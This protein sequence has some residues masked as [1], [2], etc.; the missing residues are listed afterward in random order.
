[1]TPVSPDPVT[2]EPRLFGDPVGLGVQQEE[3]L[4]EES[5]GLLSE[6]WTRRGT[7]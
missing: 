7:L 3:A 4:P 6:A 5:L 2:S 1:M